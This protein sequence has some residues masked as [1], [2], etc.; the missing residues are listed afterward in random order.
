MKA[1][2]LSQTDYLTYPLISVVLFVAIFTAAVLWVFRPGSREVYAKRS[3]MVFDDEKG[4][5]R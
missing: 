4:A 1:E 5:G 3:M 2:I